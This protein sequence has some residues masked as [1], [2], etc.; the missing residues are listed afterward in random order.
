MVEHYKILQKYNPWSYCS[1]YVR[2]AAAVEELTLLLSGSFNPIS[3]Y[4]LRVLGQCFIQIPFDPFSDDNRG[5]I[6]GEKW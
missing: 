2:M 3:C 4:H 5:G 1:S 6:H